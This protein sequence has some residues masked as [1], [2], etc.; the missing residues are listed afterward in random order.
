METSFCVL[1]AIVLGV[2][3]AVF[4]ADNRTIVPGHP[5]GNFV[6]NISGPIESSGL[7][8]SPGLRQREFK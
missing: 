3:L 5:A 8:A 1:V 7:S 6:G 2:A 4:L